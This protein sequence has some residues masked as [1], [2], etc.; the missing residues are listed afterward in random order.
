[1]R[2]TYLNCV[3]TSF[4]FTMLGAV[5]SRYGYFYLLAKG[6]KGKST[7]FKVGSTRSM[8][9]GIFVKEKVQTR[10]PP[11]KPGSLNVKAWS[12]C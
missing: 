9:E 6:K 1:M 4:G 2:S 5:F 7:F 11:R 3:V 8:L 12:S 10:K